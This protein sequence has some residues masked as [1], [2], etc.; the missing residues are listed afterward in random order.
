MKAR[1][2]YYASTLAFSF[3]WLVNGGMHDGSGI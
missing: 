1:L 2:L 3:G